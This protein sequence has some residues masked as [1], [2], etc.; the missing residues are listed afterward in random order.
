M[1][2]FT[3]LQ[4]SE[5]NHGLRVLQTLQN[6]GENHLDLL[7]AALLHDVGKTC[8]PL[9]IWERVVIVLGKQFFPNRMK[10]WGRAQT[11]SW[12]R[13]FVVASEHPSWGAE[14][15]R[16]ASA[17]PLAVYLIREHQNDH[18]PEASNP[19]VKRLLSALQVADHQN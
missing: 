10:Q 18:P 19:L 9:R 13:P 15:A 4:P 14:L 3:R 12:K 7:V 8:Y 6:Q 1:A 2:L 5:Q 17:S 11:S 16:K